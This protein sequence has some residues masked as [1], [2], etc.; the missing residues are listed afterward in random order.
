MTNPKFKVG[1]VCI[2][3]GRLPAYFTNKATNSSISGYYS[4]GGSYTVTRLEGNNKVYFDGDHVPFFL[5]M[6]FPFKPSR[7]ATF[8]NKLKQLNEPL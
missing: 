4:K 6:K 8:L 7:E 1:E 5:N 3:T 2:Y